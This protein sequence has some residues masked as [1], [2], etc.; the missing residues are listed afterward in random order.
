MKH[1]NVIAN[2]HFRKDWQRYIKTWFNQ[3]A[4]KQ[5][6]RAV[7]TEKAKAIAP[8]P[9]GTYCTCSH[10]TLRP[11]VLHRNTFTNSLRIISF[12]E[13]K[14]TDKL[15]PVVRC[16]T[17]KY[18]MRLRQ[19]R[20]FTYAELK[21]AGFKRKE[22]QGLGVCIDHRYVVEM[23]DSCISFPPLHIMHGMICPHNCKP[24]RVAARHTHNSNLKIQC[25]T[26]IYNA[27]LQPHQPL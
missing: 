6:R 21:A 16:E 7:R 27:T 3:P 13:Y 10:V 12:L 8:R 17:I 1:N 14:T 4:R 19:G 2:T 26:A 22:A 23:H 20:G 9:L 5:R 15:R 18:N 24:F 25:N 11:L